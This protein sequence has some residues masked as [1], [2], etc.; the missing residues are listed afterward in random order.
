MSTL[1]MSK[2]KA[3]LQHQ[4]LRMGSS[5]SVPPEAVIE[6]VRKAHPDAIRQVSRELEDGHMHSVLSRL[7][8]RRPKD[9]GNQADMFAD[10]PGVRQLIG[11]EIERDGRRTVEYKPIGAATLEELDAWLSA[12]RKSSATRRQRERGMVKM[13]RD[14]SKAAKGVTT[15][16]V[17]EAMVLLNAQK[18][19]AA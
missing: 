3:L 13:L 4:A 12:N 17:A 9:N 19:K 16:T 14:L 11:M 15:M 18:K 5:G 7:A 2:L 6:A 1:G 10:Y 8:S